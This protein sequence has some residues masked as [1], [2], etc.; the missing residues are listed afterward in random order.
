MANVRAAPHISPF[1]FNK[2]NR[3]PILI[4]VEIEVKSTQNL[5]PGSSPRGVLVWSCVVFPGE[6]DTWT[7]NLLER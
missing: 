5:L 3:P 4:R 7:L 1:P 6:K 2:S